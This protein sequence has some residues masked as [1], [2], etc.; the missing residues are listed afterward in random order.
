MR[1]AAVAAP[2]HLRH[3]QHHLADGDQGLRHDAVLLDAAEDI[4]ER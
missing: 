3:V 4:R 1:A 2:A